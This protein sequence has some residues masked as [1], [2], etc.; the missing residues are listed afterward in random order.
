M[1][2]RVPVFPWRQFS[3]SDPRPNPHLLFGFKWN[4]FREQN[5]IRLPWS[6]NSMQRLERCLGEPLGSF[7]CLF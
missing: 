1:W 2:K 6:L 4:Q 5:S 7:L 3:Q